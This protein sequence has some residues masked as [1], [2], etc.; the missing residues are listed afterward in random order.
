MKKRIKPKSTKP[1]QS[2][3][4][5]KSMPKNKSTSPATIMLADSS[6]PMPQRIQLLKAL[7]NDANPEAQTLVATLIEAMAAAEAENVHAEKAKQLTE[8]LQ[9]MEE[10]PLR[11]AAFIEMLD[12][13][14][15]GI[16]HAAVMLDDGIVA[17]TVVPDEELAKSLVRGDRVILDFKGRALLRK[18][19]ANWKVGEEARFERRLDDL[20]IE[21]T[22]R[23]HERHVFIAAQGLMD[24]LKAG[25]VEP[26]AA[27]VVNARQ[28]MA[29][30][31]LPPQDGLSH[32]RYLQKNT[33][34]P[35]VDAERDI[36]CPPKCIKELTD[37]IRLE[38]TKPDLRRRYRLPRCVMKLLAGVSGSGKTLAINAIWRKMYQ[39]MSEVTGVPIDQLPPRVFKLRMN[40]V[41]SKWLGDSDKNLSLFFKEVE[42]LAAEPWIAP[43]G[44]SW[45]LPVLSILEELDGLSRARNQDEPVY[46][47]I[48]TTALQALDST[49]EE[50][51]GRFIIFI[52]TT[53]EP[54][55]VDSAFMR[56]IGGTAEQ[57]GRLD[58]KGFVSV[59]QKHLRSLPFVSDNGCTQDQLERKAAHDL[60]TWLFSP[61][62]ADR[63]VLEVTYAGSATPIVKYRRD[64]FT[65]A[66]IDRA[67]RQA[68]ED[69][70]QAEDR[71]TAQPGLSLQQ[72]MR[73][74]NDQIASVVAQI[75][76]HNT[77]R[78]VDLPDGVRVATV[79]RIPQPS[80]LP[81]ELQRN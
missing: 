37:L 28:S 17:Y 8:L 78:Y 50:L 53:N 33:P 46:G 31:A 12:N 14:Q 62:G 29:F 63:G 10:G 11:N 18:V 16:R 44:K 51:R 19:P 75:D 43:D 81:I 20:H 80:H 4:K 39:V 27:L 68:A 3:P 65:G 72:L 56:R 52:G 60:T 77:G 76:E 26:G 22:L 58:R 70:A 54:Q 9:A 55:L 7:V 59:L 32:Y 15:S 25:K 35:N 34:V 73:S 40:E 74:F 2:N 13:I 41:L 61:N 45:T 24:E 47:R 21:L 48:L 67:V 64:F 69:A 71:G 6:V 66:L 79:R 1:K 57:F 5:G 30:H 36:G 23:D 38:M 49:R 42:Q